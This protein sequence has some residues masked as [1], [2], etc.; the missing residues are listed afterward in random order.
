MPLIECQ[1]EMGMAVFGDTVLCG[2]G[3]KQLRCVTCGLVSD[4]G[5]T[6][7]VDG[8]GPPGFRGE[9]IGELVRA[10]AATGVGG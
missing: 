6:K 9:P 3:D 5:G 2:V 8:G 10:N 1:P 4:T 7:A